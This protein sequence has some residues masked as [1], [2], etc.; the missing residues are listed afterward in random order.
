MPTHQW[1]TIFQDDDATPLVGTVTGGEVTDPTASTDPTHARPYLEPMRGRPRRGIDLLKGTAQIG[2]TTC[3]LLDKRVTASDQDTGWLTALLPDSRGRTALNGRRLLWEAGDLGGTRWTLFDGVIRSTALNMGELTVFELVLRDFRERLR[4]V[5]S[6]NWSDSTLVFPPG[7]AEGW[8]EGFITERGAVSADDFWLPPTQPAVG[9]FVGPGQ[10]VNGVEEGYVTLGWAPDQDSQPEERWLGTEAMLDHLQPTRIYSPDGSATYIEFGNHVVEWRLV[11]NTTWNAYEKPVITI[12]DSWRDRYSGGRYDPEVRSRRNE[13][14]EFNV[15]SRDDRNY[16]WAVYIGTPNSGEWPAH[17]A[18]V[19]VRVRWRGPATERAPQHLYGPFNEVIPRILD[20]YYFRDGDGNPID[21]GIPYNQAAFDKFSHVQVIGRITEPVAVGEEDGR[22]A[23]LKW[24]EEGA[25]APLGAAPA[26]N[27][28]NELAPVSLALPEDTTGIVQL[29]A[30]NVESMDWIDT[31]ET[32]INRIEYKHHSYLRDWGGTH[33]DAGLDGL[34][35]REDT[36]VVAESEL[37]PTASASTLLFGTHTHKVETPLLG[38]SVAGSPNL[39]GITDPQRSAIALGYRLFDRYLMGG[40]HLSGI[41]SRSTGLDV[42]DWAIVAVPWLPDYNT[43]TRGQSRLAQ[44]IDVSPVDETVMAVE[45]VDA[46]PSHAPAPQ[47][48]VS[49]VTVNAE[50]QISVTLGTIPQDATYDHAIMARV[51]VAIKPTEPAATGPEWT[52]MGRYETTGAKVGEVPMA[53]GDAWVRVRG[54]APGMVP[55]AWTVYG[56]Y[57]SPDRAMLANLTAKIGS[58]GSV[59]IEWEPYM[60]TVGIKIEADQHDWNAEPDWVAPSVAERELDAGD[61]ESTYDFDT[62]AVNERFSVRVTPYPGWDGTNVSGTAGR[63]WELTLDRRGVVEAV[64]WPT[65]SMS[66]VLDKIDPNNETTFYVKGLTGYWTAGVL[67]RLYAEDDTLLWEQTAYADPLQ[68]AVG[69]KS[70]WSDRLILEPGWGDQILRLVAIPTREA[71]VAGDASGREGPVV[72]HQEYVA[73]A[74]I[75]EPI[76]TVD[77]FQATQS[78][79]SDC[80]S[81]FAEVGLDWEISGLRP[82]DY[83]TVE[84]DVTTPSDASGDQLISDVAA[85]N[86]GNEPGDGVIGTYEHL[87][88]DFTTYAT[89]PS[90]DTVLHYWQ[91]N[92]RV[93]NASDTEVTSATAYRN[94]VYLYDCRPPLFEGDQL[95][96]TCPAVDLSDEVS[97]SI[98]ADRDQEAYEYKVERRITLDDGVNTHVGSWGDVTAGLGLPTSVQDATQ[99]ATDNTGYLRVETGSTTVTAEYRATLIRKSDAAVADTALASCFYSSDA[100]VP[101]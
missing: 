51:E 96:T 21:P 65:T 101:T 54:E 92:L 80:L 79:G 4:G 18:D 41:V 61:G 1:V 95:T 73:A 47:P 84:R 23:L 74:D 17:G 52:F 32:V 68:V 77:S 42:G 38:Q 28:D 8:G 25:F 87:D 22:R 3:R 36:V 89:T 44:V 35:A 11:G 46:G 58:G 30:S 69:A 75:Q 19:E 48:T 31:S 94:G 9:T 33:D 37:L 72:E 13:L 56:P 7:L 34:L 53:P 98:D 27:I 78:N 67:L 2:Q 39:I 99:Y 60:S 90:E 14:V 71:S 15:W 64:R 59:T 91:Y 93:Y 83:V 88:Q 55:S 62:V 29:D 57:T 16:G 6:F 66:A 100:V 26:L 5:S 40:Q 97:L 12:P 49:G 43:G 81:D 76:R 70:E 24:L 10:V 45:L 82:G 20:G 85:V 86:K 63:A 50:G